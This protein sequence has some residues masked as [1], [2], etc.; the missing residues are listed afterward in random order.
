MRSAIWQY[1]LSLPTIPRRLPPTSQRDPA[2][3]E[4]SGQLSTIYYYPGSSEHMCRLGGNRHPER[5]GL[6]LYISARSSDSWNSEM[7]QSGQLADM[8]SFDTLYSYTRQ[9]K[10]FPQVARHFIEDHYLADSA[11]EHLDSCWPMPQ[12]RGVHCSSC[13]TV[14]ELRCS[15]RLSGKARILS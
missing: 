9:K 2:S 1:R 13:R 10:A 12:Y 5:N 3:G 15:R 11:R 6:T 7:V 4:S 14:A 8:Y